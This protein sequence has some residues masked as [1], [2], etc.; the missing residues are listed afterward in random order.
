MSLF[1]RI[2]GSRKPA[3]KTGHSGSANGQTVRIDPI[4]MNITNRIAAGSA[5]SGTLKFTGGL[6]LQGNHH[7]D[8]EIEGGPLVVEGGSLTGQATVYGDAYIFGRIGG[9]EEAGDDT[10]LTVHGVLHL[11]GRAETWGLLRS[12]KLAS[13]NGAKINGS[14]QTIAAAEVG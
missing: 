5:S 1:T 14:I 4:S 7:G 13:Y 6:L 2:F 12:A 3:H 9:P 8:L 11:T 10:V